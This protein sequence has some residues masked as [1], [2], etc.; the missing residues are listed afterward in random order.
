M[1][2]VVA[3]LVVVPDVHH[4]TFIYRETH[5]PLVYPL[6]KFNDIF[7]LFHYVISKFG[8]ICKFRHFADNI[9]IK[10]IYIYIRNSSGPNTLPCGT[11]DVAG[12][13]L[14]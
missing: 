12:A 5:L 8:I 14:L 7:L 13:Q 3:L 4:R 6:K 2:Y 9:S 1:L 11:P 10:I